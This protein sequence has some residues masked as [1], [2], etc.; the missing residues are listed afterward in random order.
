MIPIKVKNL[1]INIIKTLNQV[2]NGEYESIKYN[3]KF[4]T[5]YLHKSILKLIISDSS[6]I[7][8]ILFKKTN[9]KS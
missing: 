1:Y 7:S 4:Y 9:I 8:I 6:N 2:I 3:Q 5:D